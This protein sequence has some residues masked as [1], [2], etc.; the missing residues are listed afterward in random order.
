MILPTTQ[1]FKS[2]CSC[3]Q[4]KQLR[5]GHAQSSLRL[6]HLLL[7]AMLGVTSVRA[8]QGLRLGA[9]EM[10][11]KAVEVP[12]LDFSE[13]SVKIPEGDDASPPRGSS[14]DMTIRG[15]DDSTSPAAAGSINLERHSPRYSLSEPDLADALD[16]DDNT[17]SFKAKCVGLTS[18]KDHLS[19]RV[20]DD[21]NFRYDFEE[22]P[23]HDLEERLTKEEDYFQDDRFRNVSTLLN[24]VKLVRQYQH[25]LRDYARAL[26]ESESKHDAVL[27]QNLI[28]ADIDLTVTA[29][30]LS[31]LLRTLQSFE[32][33]YNDHKRAA[34]TSDKEMKAKRKILKNVKAAAIK[35][36]RK[37]YANRIKVERAARQTVIKADHKVTR[38]ERDERAAT[39]KW[40]K[41]ARKMN[42]D[43]IVCGMPPLN[44]PDILEDHYADFRPTNSFK[45]WFSGNG[46]AVSE[47]ERLGFSGSCPACKNTGKVYTKDKAECI[48]PPT[49]GTWGRHVHSCKKPCDAC[50]ESKN[51]YLKIALK[52]NDG[53][54]HPVNTP[55]RLVGIET[56]SQLF[57]GVPQ[58]TITIGDKTYV[59]K[60]T[61]LSESR[62]NLR[63]LPAAVNV[64]VNASAAA[65]RWMRH[66][67]VQP[68]S[69]RA[70][71]RGTI[72]P[73][74]SRN[75]DIV[76][77]TVGG[78]V[79]LNRQGTSS[80]RSD[81]NDSS[82]SNWSLFQSGAEHQFGGSS[83]QN[84]SARSKGSRGSSSP[85]PRSE[86]SR[87][88]GRSNRSNPR[89]APLS[90]VTSRHFKRVRDT[91]GGDV[92]LNR[93]GSRGSPSPQLARPSSVRSRGSLIR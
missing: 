52:K 70:S 60:S 47:R 26:T 9:S 19:A 67:G 64:A 15:D 34:Q 16:S 43:R 21:G 55:C 32:Q 75:Y 10:D 79:L 68:R 87:S 44:I 33:I 6:S 38:Y 42:A 17:T 56:K 78:D 88:S 14:S 27:K 12:K 28:A 63:S 31:D 51:V 76:P 18:A 86:G 23:I 73:I 48:F 49:W 91:V 53:T 71:S 40:I 20:D 85:R 25:A 2:Y 45:G 84:D 74:A 89:S 50:Q 62:T 8:M 66:A 37:A 90:P 77:D 72:S 39:N 83:E 30:T 29:D 36:N 1:S 81:T 54:Y 24:R 65:S 93:R 57:L 80:R 82:G 69:Q 92:L 13:L 7:A 3:P 11:E 5:A 35:R 41:K 58:A 59:V 4:R 46:Y 61:D 22:K